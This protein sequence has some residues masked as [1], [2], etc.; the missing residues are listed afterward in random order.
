MLNRDEFLYK[1]L[2]LSEQNKCT[3]RTSIYT[4]IKNEV[5]KNDFKINVRGSSLISFESNSLDFAI[6]QFLKVNY[7]SNQNTIIGNGVHEGADFGYKFYLENSKYPKRRLMFKKVIEKVKKDYKYIQPDLRESYSLRTL[8]FDALRYFN[9]YWKEVMQKTIP[10]AS[11]MPLFIEVPKEM[12]LNQ[13]NF[14]KIRLTGTLDR[15]IENSNGELI[16]SDTKTSA[17]R[18]TAGISHSKELA[19]KLEEQ[20]SLINEN[21]GLEKEISNAKKINKKIEDN[22][23]DLN[24]THTDLS[25]IVF[26]NL[27]IHKKSL[28]EENTKDK[29]NEVKIKKLTSQIEESKELIK[30]YKLIDPSQLIDRNEKV[31]SFKRS[32]AKLDKTIKFNSENIYIPIEELEKKVEVNKEK[33]DSIS[34]EIEPMKK[35]YRIACA[36]G[37]ILA[38]K[39]QYGLQ[40]AFYAIM[41]MIITKKKITKLRVEVIVKNKNP[42]TQIIEWDLDEYLMQCAWEK[43]STVVAAVEAVMN[44]TDPQILFRENDISYIGSETNE[45]LNEMDMILMGSV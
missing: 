26:S 33:L 7:G 15:I 31:T 1:I 18:I 30:K 24:Q 39:K 12:L 21:L 35:E 40:L 32:Q 44:G 23:I 38:A 28:E 10:I 11:E 2:E 36:K 22:R 17:K 43:I 25:L 9:V 4:L 19:K 42:Y 16:L 37:E 45:L 6:K 27:F 5:Q 29:L 14:G 34:L 41:Y 8:T 13:E 20:Q 3:P